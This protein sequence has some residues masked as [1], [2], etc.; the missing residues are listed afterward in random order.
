MMSVLT[1]IGDCLSQTTPLLLAALG[2]AFSRR[3]GLV[4]VGLDAFILLGA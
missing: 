4:N 2:G 1:F 3:A